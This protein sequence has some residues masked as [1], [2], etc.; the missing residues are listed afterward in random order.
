MF[1]VGDDVLEAAAA[2]LLVAAVVI[3][4]LLMMGVNEVD[5]SDDA[6][7]LVIAGDDNEEDTTSL[8]TPLGED[9]AMASRLRL[10]FDFTMIVFSGNIESGGYWICRSSG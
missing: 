8:S 2:V 6:G 3:E 1:V 5:A 9:A 7:R 10:F 4:A